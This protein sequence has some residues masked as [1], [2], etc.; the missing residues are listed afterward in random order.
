[1]KQRSE[2]DTSFVSVVLPCRNEQKLIASCLD[3]ILQNDFPRD[4]LEVLVVDGMSEDGTRGILEQYSRDQP[5]IRVLDNPGKYTPFALNLGIK[6]ARGGIIIRM[7]AHAKYPQ[8]YIS[9]LVEHLIHSGADNV[10]GVW[11]TMPSRSAIFPETIALATSL[12]FGIGNA[13]YRIGTDENREVDTVPFG[14]F[15]RELFDRIG[16][17]DEELIRNQDDEFNSRIRKNGG[18]ILLVP[19]IKIEYYARGTLGSF[20]RMLFQ[21]GLYKPLV[22]L[23]MGKLTTARQLAPPLFML[24]LVILAVFFF[25]QPSVPAIF[26]L[27]PGLLYLL[28]SLSVA[29]RNGIIKHR[30]AF[31]FSL[32][33]VFFLAH[34]S[35]GTGYLLGI[36]KILFVRPVNRFLRK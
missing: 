19:S 31:V 12:P 35:Y 24:Y 17:F 25:V 33:V 27:I 36:L 29:F 4:K 20:T 18:R 2:Y 26:V 22:S 16:Y 14:C 9:A 21:Y 34:I 10:G 13:W 1:M 32:P 6:N 8:N 15:K 28:F 5:V 3:S 23:K 30:P 7:D 11:M